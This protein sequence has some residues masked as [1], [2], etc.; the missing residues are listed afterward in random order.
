ML[1]D[2]EVKVNESELVIILDALQHYKKYCTEKLE[3]THSA[4]WALQLSRI[5]IE[6]HRLYDKMGYKE[7]I[8]NG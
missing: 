4:L 1:I 2:K 3:E 8:D 5:N 6:L 7:D